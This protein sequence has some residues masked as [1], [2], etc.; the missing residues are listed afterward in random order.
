[1]AHVQ[2]EWHENLTKAATTKPL[3]AI[4]IYFLI[5]FS[6]AGILFYLGPI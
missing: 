4:E 5:K 1:M 3:N 2:A 6:H